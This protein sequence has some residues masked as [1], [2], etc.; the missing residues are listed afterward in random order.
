M[1]ITKIDF[2]SI[3]RFA[4]RTKTLFIMKILYGLTCFFLTTICF[5]Q[6]SFRMDTFTVVH[7]E[8]IPFKIE[9][10]II[11]TCTTENKRNYICSI[12]S[13]SFYGT[14]KDLSLPVNELSSLRMTWHN[15]EI[16]LP[17][18]GIFNPNFSGKLSPSQF[19]MVPISKGFALHAFFSDGEATYTVMWRV[20][21]GRYFNRLISNKEE[22]FYWQK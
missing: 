3:E 14:P 18:D 20:L 16:E 1:R 19:K 10:H 13:L 11:D 9:N 17:T 22:N 7:Y 12:D 5:S 15:M 6:D 21:E 4:T 2:R 8:I